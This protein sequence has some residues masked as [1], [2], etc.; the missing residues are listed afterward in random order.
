[1]KYPLNVL[2]RSNTFVDIPCDHSETI[3]IGT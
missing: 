3:R 2:K 1:M